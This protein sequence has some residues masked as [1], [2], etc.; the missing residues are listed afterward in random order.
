MNV[1][2]MLNYFLDMPNFRILFYGL[3]NLLLY[4][5]KLLG[6]KV[7]KLLESFNMQEF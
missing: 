1:W 4:F 7:P 6:I 3:P 5:N 2:L